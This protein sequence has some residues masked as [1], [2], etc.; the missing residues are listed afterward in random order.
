MFCHPSFDFHS[1]K[2][3]RNASSIAN[4]FANTF[5]TT[6]SMT[7]NDSFE[8]SAQPDFFGNLPQNLHTHL[9]PYSNQI[10]QL[11]AY[12]HLTESQLS[13]LLSLKHQQNL[14]NLNARSISQPLVTPT[15]NHHNTTAAGKT[16]RRSSSHFSSDSFPNFPNPPSCVLQNHHHHRTASKNSNLDSKLSCVSNYAA[17][18]ED[19]FYYPNDINGEQKPTTFLENSFTSPIMQ[20]VFYITFWT[21]KSS[22]CLQNISDAELKLVAFDLTKYWIQI[23]SQIDSV[24]MEELNSQCASETP[25]KDLIFE[26]QE[27]MSS[28]IE[29]KIKTHAQRNT[30]DTSSG[31]RSKSVSNA[32]SNCTENS[33]SQRVKINH[34]ASTKSILR[35]E[36]EVAEQNVTQSEKTTSNFNKT[37]LTEE[38]LKDKWKQS[39]K[40]VRSKSEQRRIRFSDT[41]SSELISSTSQEMTETDSNLKDAKQH[42]KK[43]H[44]TKTSEHRPDSPD[45]EIGYSKLE[46]TGSLRGL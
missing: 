27:S 39:L 42:L 40:N 44:R 17:D 43:L 8:R 38:Q 30:S 24:G 25:P 16:P 34:Q 3:K 31:I 35:Q 18:S 1:T 5:L 36:N 45:F 11:H 15:F 32:S 37:S 28:E 26:R 10:H 21:L 14:Q 29:I 13:H 9:H 22:N 6:S 4:S 2:P 12:Q 23:T 33:C 46:K 41:E 20:Y 7:S 19:R